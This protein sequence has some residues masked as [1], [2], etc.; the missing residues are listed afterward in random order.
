MLG[1]RARSVKTL[2]QDAI[3]SAAVGR[4]DYLL[5]PSLRASW[6]GPMNGQAG[7]VK[8]CRDLLAS[9]QPAA[10]VETGTYR[11]TTTKFFAEFGVP[12]HTVDMDPRLH[13]FAKL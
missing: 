1:A 8:L 6:G 9:M 3:G 7:R 13:A 11:G 5:R 2:V 12:V 4:L 10:I